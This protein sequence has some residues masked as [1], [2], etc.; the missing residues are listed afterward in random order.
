MIVATAASSWGRTERAVVQWELDDERD[1]ETAR[2]ANVEICRLHEAAGARSIFT[3]D[4]PGL[5]WNRDEEPFEAFVGRL[6]N[7]DWRQGDR[8]LGAPDVQR[9]DGTGPCDG[10]RRRT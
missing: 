10:R 8:L 3:F 7:V 2:L 5:R 9:A 1:L 6:R 4:P